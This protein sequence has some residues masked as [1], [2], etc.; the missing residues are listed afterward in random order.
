MRMPR[1]SVAVSR[2]FTLVD[3]F[4]SKTLFCNGRTNVT[5]AGEKEVRDVREWGMEECKSRRI[6]VW[7]Y[8]E[9]AYTEIE[10]TGRLRNAAR[11]QLKIRSQAFVHIE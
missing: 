8:E 5:M 9:I 4:F 10:K 7:Q 11:E 2:G 3:A 1:K 6:L